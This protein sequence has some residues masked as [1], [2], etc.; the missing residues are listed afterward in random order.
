MP[1][2]GIFPSHEPNAFATGPSKSNSLVAVSA[3]L[4]HQ[5][6][7]DEVEGVLGHEVAHVANGDMV[8]M[9]LIQGVVNAFVMFL[10][11]IAA[12]FVSQLS[13]SDEGEEGGGF[14]ALTY[15]LTV[16]VFEIIFGLLGTMITS[17]FS[18]HREF[19]A[20]RGS[21]SLVGREKMVNALARL[22]EVSMLE[23]EP[24]PEIA[25]LKIAGHTNKFLALLSTHPP[26]SV[27]I[28]ALKRAR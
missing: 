12:F 17:W 10:A 24:N 6:N 4:L 14:S 26:L 2:V 23:R 15:M 21:A 28:E 11:R 27:R 3:G 7:R 9:T 1:Q 13:S 22:S 19:R 5:M 16:F 18:R 20:D 8:T 25:S